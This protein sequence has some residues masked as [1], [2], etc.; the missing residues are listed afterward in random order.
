[1]RATDLLRRLG[2]VPDWRLILVGMT[3]PIEDEFAI[4]PGEAIGIAAEQVGS[5]IDPGPELIELAGLAA[6][7]SS[8][9]LALVRGLATHS[10][11]SPE[12]AGLLWRAAVLDEVVARL[13]DDPL[14]GTL[15]L[16]DFWRKAGNPP[17]SPM[18]FPERGFDPKDYY[19]EERY[20]NRKRAH[21]AW[22]RMRIGGGTAGS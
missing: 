2:L 12:Q 8:E 1:M 4:T 21:E 15:D 9:V 5:E 20:S 18:D 13:P 16:T 10:K 11:M 19:S 17:D 14:Y 22:V 6:D 7:D 3:E